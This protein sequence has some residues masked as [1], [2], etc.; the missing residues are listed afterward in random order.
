MSVRNVHCVSSSMLKN[1]K[2]ILQYF[3]FGN[4]Y[5]QQHF[6]VFIFLRSIG[7]F[8]KKKKKKKKKKKIGKN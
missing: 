3:V 4:Y 5:K 6:A 2:V 1:L 8:A 7:K